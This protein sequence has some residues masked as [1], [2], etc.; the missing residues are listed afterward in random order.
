MGGTDTSD[1]IRAQ[2]ALSQKKSMAAG[3][4]LT[5]FFGPLGMLYATVLGG[6]IMI[7]V[8][9]VVAIFTLGFGLIVTQ[10]IC[11][12]WAALAIKAQNQKIDLAVVGETTRRESAPPT[13][14]A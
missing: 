10:L 8:S 4:L 13:A 3:L 2:I 9:I 1:L 6:I 5:F 11:L 12:V 7:V 14:A